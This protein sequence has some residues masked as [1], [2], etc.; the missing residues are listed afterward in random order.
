MAC[1]SLPKLNK[2]NKSRVTVCFTFCYTIDTSVRSH[3]LMSEQVKPRDKIHNSL[4][5]HSQIPGHYVTLVILRQMRCIREQAPSEDSRAAYS[6]KYTG[7]KPFLTA[8]FT[9]H[10]NRTNTFGPRISFRNTLWG[11]QEGGRSASSTLRFLNS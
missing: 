8:E 6:S 10:F 3:S 1:S 9:P 7:E 11:P 5:I 4:Q 2:L